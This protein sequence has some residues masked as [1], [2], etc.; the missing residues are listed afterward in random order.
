MTEARVRA[1]LGALVRQLAGVAEVSDAA[2]LFSG[3]L[4]SVHV[5]DLLLLVE[6]LRG[7][8]IDVDALS[9]GAVRSIDAMIVAFFPDLGPEEEAA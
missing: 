1:R 8:P 7:E 4:K 6:E 5:M 9:Q 3:L 2:P